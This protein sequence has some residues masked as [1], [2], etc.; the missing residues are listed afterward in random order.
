MIQ[1]VYRFYDCVES[2][3]DTAKDAIRHKT[4]LNGMVIRAGYQL[5]GRGRQGNTWESN[6][7]QNLLFTII[8]KPDKLH[9][10]QQFVVNEQVSTTLRKQLQQL[11]PSKQVKIKWPNDIYIE[12]KKICGILIEH[13]ILGENISYSVIGMGINVNQD[14]FAHADRP[15]SLRIETGTP[16]DIDK[17]CRELS[18]ELL[19]NL[20]GTLTTPHISKLKKEYETALYQLHEEKN[21]RING[22]ETT[23]TIEGVT[24]EGCLKLRKANGAILYCELNSVVYL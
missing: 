22:Q 3:N 16:F 13:F 21:Y 6:K 19:K 2:T 11:V 18:Y 1:P 8:F 12:D 14:T 4:A 5:K 7:D 15:T 10:A 17:L 23:A 20:S 9:P 24:Q